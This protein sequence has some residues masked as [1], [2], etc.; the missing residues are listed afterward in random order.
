MLLASQWGWPGRRFEEA[1]HEA[2]RVHERLQLQRAVQQ[3][4]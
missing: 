4:D 3:P 2:W 1:V